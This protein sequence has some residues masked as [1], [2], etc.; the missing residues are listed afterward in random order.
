MSGCLDRTGEPIDEDGHDPRCRN[1]W[2]DRDA[3]PAVPCLVCKPHL[4]PNL[5]RRATLDADQLR[6]EPR[7]PE[8]TSDA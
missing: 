3:D 4:A 8:G 2:L 1:G 5:L 7:N 6:Q